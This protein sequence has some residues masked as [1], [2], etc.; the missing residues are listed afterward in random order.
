MWV[1][2]IGDSGGGFYVRIGRNWYLQG[3]TSNTKISDN[4]V[5]PTCNFAS[6]AVF[7][8]VSYYQGEKRA[9]LLA[10]QACESTKL[11]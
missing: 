10:L 7:T 4:P 3:L 9:P 8:N 5:N 2:P 6:Y 1:N 11:T